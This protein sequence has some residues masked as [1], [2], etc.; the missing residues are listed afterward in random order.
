M[1]KNWMGLKSYTVSFSGGYESHP[2][3]QQI[4]FSAKQDA[5]NDIRKYHDIIK[6]CDPSYTVPTVEDPVQ[7]QL[8]IVQN[9]GGCYVATAV[10]GSYDCPQVWTLRRYRDY[11]LAETWYGRAFIHVYYAISP[12]LV[13]WFGHT[14]WF[15]KLWQKR[16]DKM[17]NYLNNRGVEDTP[18]TDR[19]W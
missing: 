12:I 10:Y 7:Q 1:K 18:Y 2:I 16:L 3:S 6:I 11:T 17:V 19:N 14:K 13:K 9:T 15:K 4:K 5:T 8:Q